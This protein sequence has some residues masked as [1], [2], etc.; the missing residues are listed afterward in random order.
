MKVSAAIKTAL[1]SGWA[2]SQEILLR[3][4]HRLLVPIAR[5]LMRNGIGYPAFAEMAKRAFVE[6]AMAPDVHGPFRTTKARTALLTGLTRPEVRRIL[7]TGEELPHAAHTARIPAIIAG[8]ATDPLFLDEEGRPIALP[9]TGSGRSFET[10]I[11]RFGADIPR[12]TVLEELLLSGCVERRHGRLVL[13]DRRYRSSSGVD[14]LR[15]FGDA[16]RRSG[17]TIVR[18]LLREGEPFLQREVWSRAI[19]PER[20]ALLRQQLRELLAAQID[21]SLALLDRE[22]RLPARPDHRTVGV[23]YYYFES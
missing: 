13:L 10:L 21:D 14:P 9:E 6:A 17:D 18:N 20:V 19:P 7:E 23:G 3:S 8:W 4:L 16:T 11:R 5:L 12:A 22:E 15:Y 2:E 1:A